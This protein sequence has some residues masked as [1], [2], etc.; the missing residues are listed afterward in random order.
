VLLAPVEVLSVRYAETRL[1]SIHFT[2]KR[3]LSVSNATTSIILNVQRGNELKNILFKIYTILMTRKQE[4]R[5]CLF[6]NV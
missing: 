1:P 3:W 5:N 6:K 2:W 4:Q